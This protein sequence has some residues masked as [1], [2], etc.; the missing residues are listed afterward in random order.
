MTKTDCYLLD[1]G[2][3]I[4]SR[5]PQSRI[6]CLGDIMI[7][8]FI[9]GA[10]KR[11]SPES[12]VPVFNASGQQVFP[13][14]AANVARNIAAL[15]GRC[16]LIGVTG[17]D[18]AARELASAIASNAGIAMALVVEA[19]RPTTEKTRYVTDGHHMLRVDIEI[20]RPITEATETAILSRV[21]SL[22]SS[23]DVLV[24][25][26]YAK[27]V[28]TDRVVAHAIE[29]A[30]AA[31]RPIIV[32]PK[33]KTLERYRGASLITP[34]AKETQEATGIDPL[35]DDAMAVAAGAACHAGAPFEAVLIT[36]SEKGMTL[37]PRDGDPVHIAS[38]GREVFDVVG[39][40][41]TVVATLAVARAAGAGWETAAR[42]A[43]AAA[44]VVV[45]KRGT[46]T[47]S[48]DELQLELQSLSYGHTRHD[49]PVMLTSEDAGRYARIRKAEGK[50]VGFTN[51][52]FD[53]LHPGHISILKFSR[54]A[55]DC[56]IVGINSDASVK[57]LK[58]PTRPIN[59]ETDRATVLG[60]LG[61]VDAVVLFDTDTPLEL[62]KAIEPDVLIKGADYTVET[63]V[64]SDVVQSYGGTVL[65]APLVAGKSSTNAIARAKL[66]RSK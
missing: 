62:I 64:G 59:P 9:N 47:V 5:F 50:R 33:S 42:I 46:A 7:D 11:I 61:T 66:E 45:G 1:L 10:V 43:N 63:V 57:R 49:A 32:D 41:D 40:G 24:L 26:D 53:I 12:P 52:V 60:A 51:G 38:T 18:P 3:E 37:I 54:S 39:A 35:E 36:R 34:N 2:M 29:L 25:S 21:E 14:G 56:L 27:G 44:G 13:G 6:L 28:L 31:G 58:G 4:I 20:A 17:D 15:G 8:R 65:L 30:S 48:S 55:C 22:V 16:T 19:E 23:H